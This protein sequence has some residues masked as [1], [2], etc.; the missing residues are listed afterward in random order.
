MTLAI[1]CSRSMLTSRI[2]RIP[3][4][5][6]WELASLAG[7]TSVQSPGPVSRA[8]P[9]FFVE[10][11]GYREVDHKLIINC[12]LQLLVQP[13]T[14]SNWLVALVTEPVNGLTGLNSCAISLS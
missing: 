7:G 1:F 3:E 10:I 8:R 4:E 12:G 13:S 2:G 6:E 11:Y 14:L 5:W 9:S